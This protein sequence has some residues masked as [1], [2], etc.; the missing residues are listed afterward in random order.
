MKEIAL[1]GV[2]GTVLA[3]V[4]TSL[5]EKGKSVDVFTTEPS[6]IMLDTTNVTVNRLDAESKE[7]MRDVLGGFDTIIIAVENNLADHDLN[8][9][10]LH[11]YSRIVNAA[12]DAGAKKLIV[13]GGK[14]SE[15]FLC[16]ELR[17]HKDLDY[18]FTTTEGDYGAAVAAVV[19]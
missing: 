12:I 17:R 14:D 10:I 8:D 7:A 15:A 18:S 9:F 2:N 13:V 3:D 1:L 16:G 11:N 19:G 5:L 4:L 6:R